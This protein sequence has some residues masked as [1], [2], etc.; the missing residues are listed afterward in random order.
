MRCSKCVWAAHWGAGLAKPVG[1]MTIVDDD[2]E[3]LVDSIIDA[4]GPSDRAIVWY[5]F[6]HAHNVFDASADV[7][8]PM[9]LRPT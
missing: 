4:L 3:N 1:I 5:D 9:L 6:Q 7:R 8:R 2:L